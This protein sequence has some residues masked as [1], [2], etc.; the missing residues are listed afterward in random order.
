MKPERRAFRNRLEAAA[1][2]IENKYADEAAQAGMKLKVQRA[3]GVSVRGLSDGISASSDWGRARLFDEIVIDFCEYR[4]GSRKPH[5][6]LQFEKGIQLVEEQ[7]Q[8]WIAS[9]P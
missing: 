1:A 9:P 7:I 8:Q 3:A 4:W 5:V 2:E 6:L